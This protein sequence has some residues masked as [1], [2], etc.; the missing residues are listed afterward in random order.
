MIYSKAMEKLK[1]TLVFHLE[2]FLLTN[3]DRASTSMGSHSL[4]IN[5]HHHIRICYEMCSIEDVFF[6]IE[7]VL[8]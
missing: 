1:A 6:S 4:I 5:I 8:H 7:D 3:Q 2:F